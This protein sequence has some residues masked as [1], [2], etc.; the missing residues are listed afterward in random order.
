MP[1]FNG[2]EFITESIRSVQSQTFEAWE[3]IIVDDGS[4]DAT[5]EM[6][7]ICQEADAR[8]KYYRQGNRKQ[9]AA[10]NK[11]VAHAEGKWI[12]FLDADDVW[13]PNK[14][15]EQLACLQRVTADVYYSYGFIIN[16]FGDLVGSYETISGFTSAEQM[17]KRLYN[18][19]PIPVLSVILKREWLDRI[20]GFDEDTRFAG[21]EDLDLWLRLSRAGADFYGIEEKLFKYRMHTNSASQ[22]SLQMKMAEARVMYNNYN[23]SVFNEAEI[24]IIK[25][26]VILLVRSIVPKLY[27]LKK[28]DGIVSF[29]SIIY[30]MTGLLKYKIGMLIFYLLRYKSKRAIEFLL[31]H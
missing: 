2:A 8:I 16:Q 29:L 1:V 15:T 9:A 7:R 6:V 20:G 14:L 4:T 25:K 5:S 17:Y 11:A 26:R 31:F 12:A 21:C 30:K 10:R 19:N 3:L 23:P 24:E 27:D 28:K 18:G 13:L 22:D